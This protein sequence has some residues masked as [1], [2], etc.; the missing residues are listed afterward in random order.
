MLEPK[1]CSYF[2]RLGLRLRQ[3][4]IFTKKAI[5][6]QQILHGQIF[7]VLATHSIIRSRTFFFVVGVSQRPQV[8]RKLTPNKLRT[9]SEQTPNELRMNS[10][11]TPSKL[12]TNS[13]RTPNELRTNS[14]QTPNKRTS[15]E[16]ALSLVDF[17]TNPRANSEHTLA[18][19]M[20]LSLSIL[21]VKLFCCLFFRAYQKRPSDYRGQYQQVAWEGV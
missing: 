15:S 18:I 14:G 2:C 1:F 8:P 11:Q 10:E 20:F 5:H 13:E 4:R 19:S 21:V 6:L 9:N 12:R 7:L 16:Q 17:R 3:L